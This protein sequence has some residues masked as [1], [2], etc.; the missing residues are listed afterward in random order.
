MGSSRAG[1]I[2]DKRFIGFIAF[3]GLN[4]VVTYAVYLLLTGVMHYQWAY[5]IAYVAGIALAY[6]FNLRLVFRARSSIGKVIL[7]PVIY[8][9]QY[10]FG[11]GLM[12]LLV[13]VLDFSRIWAPLLVVA[14]LM[15]VSFLTNKALL[16]GGETGD[17]RRNSGEG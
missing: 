13:R 2:F 3:G 4:T 10:A 9:V 12:D 14:L 8:P 11:A 5:L 16:I 6:M 17:A 15:P 1:G 7:Y